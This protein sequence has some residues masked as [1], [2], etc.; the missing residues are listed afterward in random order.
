MEVFS[1]T[2]IVGVYEY[3]I[4]RN[5]EGMTDLRTKAASF[6][7]GLDCRGFEGK[8]YLRWAN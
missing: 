2:I 6:R 4:C 7:D 1:H 3:K 5:N 8:R